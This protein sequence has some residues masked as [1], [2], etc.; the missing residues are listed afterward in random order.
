MRLRM[1]LLF[2]HQRI[3]NKQSIPDSRNFGNAR[4][5]HGLAR[6]GL[7]KYKLNLQVWRCVHCGLCARHE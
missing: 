2:A 4:V 5:I 7:D 1:L 3:A 6:V